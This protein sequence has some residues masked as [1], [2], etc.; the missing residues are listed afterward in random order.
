M[1]TRYILLS[2]K[3]PPFNFLAKDDVEAENYIEENFNEDD[4]PM[5]LYRLNQVCEWK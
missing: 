3:Y 5:K 2:D 1:K 4:G